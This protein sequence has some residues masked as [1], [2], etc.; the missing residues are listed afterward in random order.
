MAKHSG[1]PA[2]DM[3]TSD[4]TPK[5]ISN[6]LALNDASACK[7]LV[8]S[9]IYESTLPGR[10]AWQTTRFMHGPNDHSTGSENAA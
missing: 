1:K 4:P 7:R 5:V 2:S 10:L 8:E 3:C 9:R 6:A